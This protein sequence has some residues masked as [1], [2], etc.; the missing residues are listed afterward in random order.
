MST[1]TNTITKNSLDKE[2]VIN[3][4]SA[5]YRKWTKEYNKALRESEKGIPMSKEDF[6]YLRSLTNIFWV[7]NFII[8][9]DYINDKWVV[10]ESGDKS[11]AVLYVHQFPLPNN[12]EFTKSCSYVFHENTLYRKKCVEEVLD[13][14]EHLKIVWLYQYEEDLY[15]QAVYEA[16]DK[17]AEQKKLQ[18]NA[19]FKKDLIKQTKPE[20]MK[21]VENAS[22][23]A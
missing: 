14:I 4:P 7:Q 3:L 15:Y 18:R 9:T 11:T 5:S 1:T 22:V 20:K 13:L 6:N 8:S 23:A 12:P 19:K 21:A 16:K 2:V 17:I 10:L